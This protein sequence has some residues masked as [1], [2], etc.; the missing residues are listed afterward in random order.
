MASENGALDPKVAGQAFHIT[1]GNPQ[2]F[3]TFAQMI[4]QAAGD[5]T[6]PDQITVIPAWL[7]LSLVHGID[8]AFYQC[9]LG[10]VRPPLTMNPLYIQ[11]T[12][13]DATYDIGKSRERFGYVPVVDVEGHLRS[14]IA[15]ECENHPERYPKGL[16]K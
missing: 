5:K 3:W 11:Y 13:Y 12:I 1:D 6:A 15:W 9:I 4:L 7:A 10:K 14:S 16:R 8:W 2:P